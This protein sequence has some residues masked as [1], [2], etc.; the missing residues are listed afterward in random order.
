MLTSN[1][2]LDFNFQELKVL[3]YKYSERIQSLKSSL[4]EGNLKEPSGNDYLDSYF[5]ELLKSFNEIQ[6]E[7]LNVLD[8]CHLYQNA[9]GK[10]PKYN[11]D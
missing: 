6:I 11:L 10:I 4:N 5:D 7:N 1:L 8:L 9:F 3:S 2:N